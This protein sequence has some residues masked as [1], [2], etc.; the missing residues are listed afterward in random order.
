MEYLK[1]KVMDKDLQGY[2]AL[3]ATAR[4]AGSKAADQSGAVAIQAAKVQANGSTLLITGGLA[5]QAQSA[6]TLNTSTRNEDKVTLS[7][8]LT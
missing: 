6:A 5:A 8:V 2:E 3:E 7:E 1:A 4:N